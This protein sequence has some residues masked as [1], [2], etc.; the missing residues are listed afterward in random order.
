MNRKTNIYINI[1]LAFLTVQILFSCK[2]TS[3][4]KAGEEEKPETEEKIE[5]SEN[6]EVTLT[7]A[8]YDASEIMLG[9]FENKNLSE[10]INANGYTKLPPQNQADVSVFMAGIV[11]S[12][13]VIEGEFVKAGQT[14]ATLESP[15]FTRLQESFLISKSNT[16]FLAAE[17]ER[18]KTLSDENVNAKKAYQKTKADFETEKARFNSLQKQL[19]M[20]HISGTGSANIVSTVAVTAPISG[21]ITEVNVKIGSNV[22]PGTSLFSIVDNT[23]MHVDLLVYEKDL[24]KVKPDQTVRFVLTNQDNAE[25]HG[26]IFS[27]G[28]AF[29]NETKSVAVHADILNDKQILIPGM[30]V[31][32]LIDIGKNKVKALPVDAVIKADGR[33]FIFV[34]EDEQGKKEGDEKLYHFQRIEIKSGTTQ[35]GYVQVTPLQVLEKNAK[36]VLKGSYYIQSHLLKSDE[37]GGHEH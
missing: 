29:E 23:K 14:I 35:L 18:Q 30:Y 1:L 17:F 5:E 26:K 32:A 8:Q 6:K 28:K 20:L 27:V 2:N 21:Y 15:E 34:L 33:E 37:R 16:E 11:K 7:Q 9:T 22:Q 31:N 3:G 24:Q 12:I 13:K 36:I 25:I 4:D 10:V 19:S